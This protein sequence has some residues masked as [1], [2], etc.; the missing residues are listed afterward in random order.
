MIVVDASVLIA[1]LDRSDRHH[2][3]AI[4]LLAESAPPFVVH[5]LTAAEVLV[6]PTRAGIADKV[7]SDLVV[8]GVEV[9]DTPVDP[10]QLARLRADTGCKMPDCCVIATALNRGTTV[11]TFD[12]RLRKHT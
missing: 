7:W 1:Y 10:T 2:A 5:P 3:A 8:I 12:K 11:A 9:D 6:S 4:E